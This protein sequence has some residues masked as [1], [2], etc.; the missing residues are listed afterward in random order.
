MASAKWQ[1]FWYDFSV[2]THLPLDQDEIDSACNHLRNI[3]SSKNIWIDDIFQWCVL[4]HQSYIKIDVDNG[5]VMGRGQAI[6]LNNNF[7][8]IDHIFTSLW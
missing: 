1:P 6:D 8:F 2:L 4:S 5:L 7:P 3:F